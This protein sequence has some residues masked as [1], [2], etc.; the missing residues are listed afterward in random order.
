MTNER[1]LLV[2]LVCGLMGWCIQAHAG[3]S[4]IV[5]DSSGP[6]IVIAAIIGACSAFGAAA[7]AAWRKL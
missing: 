2:A 3:Q 5:E 6:Y 4:I 7:W 1:L